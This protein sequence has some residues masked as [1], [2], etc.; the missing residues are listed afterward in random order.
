MTFTRSNYL[1]CRQGCR[2]GPGDPAP[3]PGSIPDCGNGVGR[4]ADRA[5]DASERLDGSGPGRAAGRGRRPHRRR[6][7]EMPSFGELLG[8]Q[9]VVQR[10]RGTSRSRGRRRRGRRAGRGAGSRRGRCRVRAARSR[11]RRRA[12]PC[13]RPASDRRDERPQ[14]ARVQRRAAGHRQ[15]CGGRD[16]PAHAESAAAAAA[17][18]L[19]VRFGARPSSRATAALP[20]AICRSRHARVRGESIPLTAPAARRPHRLDIEHPFGMMLAATPP[21]GVASDT[22]RRRPQA[23]DPPLHRRDAAL[24]RL[25][26]VGSRDRARGRPQLHVGRAPPPPDARARRLPRARRRPVAGDPPDAHGGARAGPHPASS[27]RS[28]S[29]PRRTSCR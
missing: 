8:E 13:A 18:G 23:E 10:R 2:R 19:A 14:Q 26:A 24:A 16:H 3:K 7:A 4:E 6:H 17:L 28:R 22:T 21:M 20:P 27:S 25:P 1:P 12:S 11:A 29:P 5:G 9:D 15:E